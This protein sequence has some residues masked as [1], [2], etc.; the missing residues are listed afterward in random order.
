MTDYSLKDLRC[1]DILLRECHVSR[2]AAHFGFSQ[3]AMSMVLSRLRQVFGDPLLVRQGNRLQPTDFAR[4]LHGRVRDM[5]RE[6]EALIGQRQVFDPTSSSR[7][8]TLILTDYIDTILIPK[9][10]ARLEQ[11]GAR[12]SLKI[13]GPNP[14]RIG[15][16]FN[17]GQV[18]LTV[19]YFPRPPHNLVT[20]RAFSDRLV[21][22]VRRGHPVLREPITIDQF[23]ALDHVAIE[24]AEATMY[25]M[26]LDDALFALG[27][28]RHIT[29]SKPDFSGVP[30]L[31]EASDVVATMPARLARVYQQ[32]FDLVAFDPPLELPLLDIRMM[33]HRSTQDSAPHKW[34]RD[35]LL[36]VMANEVE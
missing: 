4:A 25:R 36:S 32:R 2:A 18:D 27:K 14:L 29:V 1:L 17:E 16:L 7:R 21:C 8:F 31:L 20:R 26:V 28:A 11:S 19:S 5:I 3:P 9:L 10:Y 22:M 35:Q 15:D 12:I 34:L 30:V 6:M 13:V 23:C 24:P 33:W